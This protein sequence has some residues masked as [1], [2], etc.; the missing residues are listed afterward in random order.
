M[1][2]CMYVSNVCMYVCCLC[3][4]CMFIMN[5]MNVINVFNVMN[6]INVMF[7]INVCTHEEN[8]SVS[9]SECFSSFVVRWNRKAPPT[10]AAKAKLS[11]CG[12]LGLLCGLFIGAIR[13]PSFPLPR[14]FEFFQAW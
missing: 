4:V 9:N 1:Y 3:N 7:V 5:V 6:V 2:V 8:V 10:R 12:C 13:P 14:T 11:A